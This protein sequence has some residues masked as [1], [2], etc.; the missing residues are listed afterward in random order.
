MAFLL[1][2]LVVRLIFWLVAF[3]NPDEAYYWLWGQ[4]PEWSYYDH[5]PFHAWTQGLFAFALGRSEFVVRLPNLIS[6]G[7]FF[8]VYY[9]IC[10][11]LYP[12]HHQGK[13]KR[14]LLLLFASPLYFLFL[15]L[16]WHDHWLITFSLLGMYWF[17]SFADR[18]RETG[19]GE[20][21]RLLGAG[22]AMGLALLCKYSAV[23]V[24]AGFFATIVTDKK[25]RPLLWNW[26][27]Y[28]AGAIVAVGLIPILLWNLQN[29]WQS[30]QYYADRSVQAAGF[31]LRWESLL[32]F[33][34]FS[35]LM[36]SPFHCWGFWQVLRKTSPLKVLSPVYQRI[37]FWVFTISTG[38][39][40]I[41]SLLSAAL[42]YWNILAYLLLFPLVAGL[43]S[44]S[45]LQPNAAP[46]A[47]RRFPGLGAKVYGLLFASLLV[48][49]YAIF[50]LSALVSQDGDPD[51]RMLY[52][53]NQVEQVVK[54][55]MNELG[56]DRVVV[57]FTTDYRSA[58]A[59]AYQLNRSDVL[60]ISKRIDQFD[61]WYPRDYP[62]LKGKPALILWDDWHP[63]TDEVRSQLAAEPGAIEI[64]VT[65][66]G[67]W[68]KNYYLTT[69][70]A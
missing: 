51:S 46:K 37:T 39:L 17:I 36:V 12:E 25:L 58:S 18:Y 38:T 53:W 19:K 10:Q 2:F 3:P 5:P 7:L 40:C 50:P 1:V 16:A 20:T 34:L 27:L 63:L 55:K 56:G 64:P 45:T 21:W 68:I 26:R 30:F 32:G 9:K 4:R 29:D 24:L 69:G 59:L 52:G 62:T 66:F 6:N 54:N 23:F 49:H 43:G 14:V 41:V 48:V 47:V 35:I 67:K 60:A 44:P 70:R 11:Y 15:A 33:V 22:V 8:Y 42:Y 57:L 65:R 13:F 31:S 28:A 61:F